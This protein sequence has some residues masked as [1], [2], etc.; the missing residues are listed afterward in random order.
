MAKINKGCVVYAAYQHQMLIV[1]VVVVAVVGQWDIKYFPVAGASSAGCNVLF[2]LLSFLTRKK[3][4]GGS[5]QKSWHHGDGFPYFFI[6]FSCRSIPTSTATT[7]IKCYLSMW[8]MYAGLSM[9]ELRSCKQFIGLLPP[10]GVQHFKCH[11]C[12]RVCRC[13]FLFAGQTF[14]FTYC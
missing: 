8:Y 13:S 2:V 3:C 14:A 4:R 10:Q 9:S 12:S 7:S 1:V 6:I 5:T 11:L